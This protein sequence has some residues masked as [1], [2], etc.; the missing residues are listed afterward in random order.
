M[1]DQ[2]NGVQLILETAKERS[3]DTMVFYR[4][5]SEELILKQIT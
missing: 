4:H 3:R 2:D 1:Q 5:V